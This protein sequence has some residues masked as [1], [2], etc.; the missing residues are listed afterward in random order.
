MRGGLGDD[1]YVVD[2]S[3][4]SVVENANSGI[5]TVLSKASSYTLAANVE[6]LTL[7][8]TASQIGNGNS[9]N[10]IL[11]SNDAGSKLS[12]GDGNDILIAGR[13]A[14]TLTGGA[15]TDIFQFDHVPTSAGHVTDFTVGTDMLD[16]RGLFTAVGYT[17]SNPVADSY[18]SFVS[19]GVGGT[20]V[21]F[22]PDGAGP[23]GSSLITTLDHVSPASLTMGS[24]WYFQTGSST[25]GGGTTTPPPPSPPPPP[26]SGGG[27]SGVQPFTLPYTGTG[28]QTLSSTAPIATLPD[29]WNN[30]VLSGSAAQTGNGN[31]VDNI[32]ISNDYGSTLNG[33]AGND[34]LKSGHSGDI[35][36]GG[37]GN[38]IFEF[39]YLPWHSGHITDFTSGVDALDLR[40]LFQ[41]AG[42]TG[43]DPVKDGWLSFTSDGAG[44]TQVFFD[45]H[46]G[47][48]PYFITTLDGVS[49]SAHIDFF[50]H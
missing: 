42:Y 4:D 36:T 31:S 20:K 25:S 30:L 26:P 2:R 14:D 39:D 19:D 35:L 32:I 38:D 11:T 6:N 21:I 46:N 9:L 10:N 45:A 3:S 18:L 15:G 16:L 12:G 24:D 49:P 29:G 5:D 43:T 50:F 34:I 1:T 17:G 23:A 27:T 33:G 41:A 48:W 22:D 37:P 47:T 40:P 8:G 28:I 44:N 13:G 7:I